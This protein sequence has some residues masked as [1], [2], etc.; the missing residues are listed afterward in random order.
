MKKLI[1]P[2]CNTENEPQYIFCKNCGKQLTDNEKSAGNDAYF[3]SQATYTNDYPN[4]DGQVIDAID[5]ISSE[6][7]AIYIG[8][9][10]GRI[11]PKFSKMELTGSKISWCWPVA[12]LG[13]L[14]GPIGAAMWFFYRKIYKVACILMVI[15]VVVSTATTLLSGDTALMQETVFKQLESGTFDPDKIIEAIDESESAYSSVANSIDSVVDLLTMV[16]CG[17]FAYHFYKKSIVKNIE[18]YKAK[19]VDPRYYRMGLAA[20]GGTSVGMAILGIVAMS[21]VS[22]LCTIIAILVF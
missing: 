16:L 8:K 9:K 2:E 13:F 14:L 10:S 11:L 12:I 15:G 1:C 4:P 20:I 22:E 6:D 21:F 18:K 7:I 5:S 17:M 19:N 3:S